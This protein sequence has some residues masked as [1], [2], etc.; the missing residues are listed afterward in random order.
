MKPQRNRLRHRG[1]GEPR[2]S[3]PAGPA[4]EPALQA[5][6]IS[7]GPADHRVR[8]LLRPGATEDYQDP[9]T[10]RERK[11]GQEAG[12]VRASRILCQVGERASCHDRDRD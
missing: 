8:S 7:T 10:S 1:P 6:V 2:G 4:V 3:A 12:L 11:A 9:A 5:W